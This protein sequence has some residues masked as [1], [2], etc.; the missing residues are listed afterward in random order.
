MNPYNF[1]SYYKNEKY[2]SYYK[3]LLNYAYYHLIFDSQK[4][5]NNSNN[6]NYNIDSTKF[7]FLEYYSLKQKFLPF[8]TL[9]KYPFLFIPIYIRIKVY[10]L[11][12]CFCVKKFYTK[13]YLIKDFILLNENIVLDGNEF[14]ISHL[15][16]E[17]RIGLTIKAFDSKF[18]K[19]YIL[20]SCQIPLYKDTG[21]FNSGEIEYQF[22]PNVKIFPRVVFSTPFS[23]KKKERVYFVRF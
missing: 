21:E 12:G 23:K 1:I 20:G 2:N 17:T 14:L 19:K 5:Q 13:P 22:W 9:E 7:E 6:D 4:D 16:Y 8:F 15:P 11:Y 10:I 18:E 3:L